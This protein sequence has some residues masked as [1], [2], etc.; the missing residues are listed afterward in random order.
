VAERPTI[1]EVERLLEAAADE[2]ELPAAPSGL[3]VAVTDR[4]RARRRAL[5]AARP[6]FAGLAA[7][8]RRRVLL[9]VAAA[10]LLLACAIGAARL[11]VV[12]AVEVRVVPSATP[13]TGPAPS[14]GPSLGLTEARS[15]VRFPIVVPTA[16]GPPDEVHVLGTS[17]ARRV[18]LL[19]WRPGPGLPPVGGTPWGAMLMELPSRQGILAVKDVAEQNSFQRLRVGGAPGYWTE[20]AHDLVLLTGPRELRL[21]VRGNVLL[22]DVGGVTYRLETALGREDALRLAA[23][24]P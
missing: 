16:L 1:A 23:S 19:A 18:A 11:V 5:G 17:F 3:S 2:L 6:P 7:W 12:G 4:I 21:Y 20:G 15:M 10:L 14:L 13:P 22:W 8:P 24:L 9:L